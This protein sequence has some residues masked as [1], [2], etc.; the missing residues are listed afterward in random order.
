M[1]ICVTVHSRTTPALVGSKK[2]FVSTVCTAPLAKGWV[3][4]FRLVVVS[5]D[6][7]SPLSI[8]RHKFYLSTLI[9]IVP[10]VHIH[11]P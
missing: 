1:K 11:V 6:Q 9:P 8:I 7:R 4:S 2:C 5:I 3:G 10:I